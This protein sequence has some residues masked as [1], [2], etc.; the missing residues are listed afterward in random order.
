MC[1]FVPGIDNSV[2][3]LKCS[4]EY[5]VGVSPLDHH[6]DQLFKASLCWFSFFLC[7]LYPV[8]HP[9]AGVT[10]PKYSSCSQILVLS[11]FFVR[12]T[13]AKAPLLPHTIIVLFK[14]LLQAPVCIRH[15][16]TCLCTPTMMLAPSLFSAFI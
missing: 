10:A 3:I 6:D 13:W 1:S 14:D 5:P 2:H 7:S 8:P 11:C 15:K 4:S 9:D 16:V 12:R